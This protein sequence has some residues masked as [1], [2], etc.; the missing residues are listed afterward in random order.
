VIVVLMILMLPRS[1]LLSRQ[2][3]GKLGSLLIAGR[4]LVNTNMFILPACW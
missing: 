4:E 2:Y 3:R 1:M